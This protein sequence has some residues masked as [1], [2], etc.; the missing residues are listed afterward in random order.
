M[1]GKEMW[2]RAETMRNDRT[3]TRWKIINL[4]SPVNADLKAM[5]L[6]VTIT[7]QSEILSTF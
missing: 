5:E 2:S 6:A 7:M 3:I 1:E 4:D